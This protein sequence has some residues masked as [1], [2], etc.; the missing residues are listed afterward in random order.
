MNTEEIEETLSKQ[1]QI[2][3]LQA[4][5]TAYAMLHLL[6]LMMYTVPAP[7]TPCS[8]MPVFFAGSADDADPSLQMS[9]CE[10]SLSRCSCKS[11]AEVCHAKCLLH[12]AQC[13]AIMHA[14]SPS[15]NKQLQVFCCDSTVVCVVKALQVAQ[16]INCCVMLGFNDSRH[17]VRVMSDVSLK[18]LEW[19]KR[20]GLRAR[21]LKRADSLSTRFQPVLQEP[22]CGVTS[23]HERYH[24]A[25][26]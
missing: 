5:S 26:V 10:C 18:K 25:G 14:A 16:L 4:A 24:A 12:S 3:L 9:S 13:A 21:D 15:T 6:L 22:L 23:V 8:L 17:V 11:L 7:V 1:T 2:N 19:V 20:E